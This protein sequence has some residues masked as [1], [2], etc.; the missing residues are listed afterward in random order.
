MDNYL[1]FYLLDAQ[2][3]SLLKAIERRCTDWAEAL[4]RASI[5]QR[6]TLKLRAVHASLALDHNSVSFPQFQ[7]VADG[8]R[9]VAL[10]PDIKQAQNALAVYQQM[11]SYQPYQSAELCHAHAAFMADVT[12]LAGQY[13]RQGTGVYEDHKLVHMPPAPSQVALAVDELLDEL[14][15]CAL[16]PLVSASLAHH[17][18]AHI[19]PF[20]EGN[21]RLCRFWQQLILSKW[22]WSF[23][24]L[25][26]SVELREKP[27]DYLKTLWHQPK[28]DARHFVLFMLR[29]TQ[30]ALSKETDALEQSCSD[31]QL[32]ARYLVDG[33][34]VIQ[35]KIQKHKGKNSG[36][37]YKTEEQILK[38]LKKDN[39][40]SAKTI[41]D[42]LGLSAR[43]VEKQ[44]AKLKAAGKLMRTGPA[45]GGR[46]QVLS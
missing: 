14:R 34:K 27:R 31:A 6:R 12:A 26:L 8:K 20:S 17:Q 23:D 44:F 42:E 3:V 32:P 19:H 9:V 38:K 2:V 40:L 5:E 33:S 46:W 41:A 35:V 24:Y 36:P 21:G 30:E 16:H 45:K 29:C 18:L 28:D 7:E 15:T 22:H 39:R 25:P 1:A 4:S 37:W 10:P 11:E 43:A 13:R